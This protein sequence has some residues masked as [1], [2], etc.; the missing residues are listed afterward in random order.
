MRSDGCWPKGPFASPAGPGKPLPHRSPPPK[1]MT[2]NPPLR[3]DLVGVLVGVT[4]RHSLS[5]H[6]RQNPDR[7]MASAVARDSRSNHGHFLLVAKSRIRF[8]RALMLS[9]AHEK[10]RGRG[11]DPCRAAGRL[12]LRRSGRTVRGQPFG[13]L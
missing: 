2:R 3:T 12:R 7:E 10:Y 13:L 9:P 6:G 5:G 1:P 4:R 11:A 8:Q